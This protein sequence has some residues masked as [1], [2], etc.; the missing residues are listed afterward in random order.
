MTDVALRPVSLAD[1]D[2]F[3]EALGSAEGTGAFQWFGFTS[4]HAVRRRFAEDGLLGPDGGVLSV[5]HGEECVG[6]VEWFAST[7][8]RPATS[9]CWTIA[10][11]LLPAWRGKGFG[12]MA[13]GALLDYLFQ[14][15]RA[16]RVQAFTDV[17]NVAERRSL[18][19]CGFA[20]EGVLRRAQWRGG[21]W[22]DQALYSALRP[23]PEEAP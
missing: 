15:T 6:R 21:A 8:G 22:H 23:G 1:L 11:G 20:L 16:T 12:A 10:I 9:T 19:R 5:T 17:G 3:E 14:H 13:Q 2:L 7:W 4:F 18:E